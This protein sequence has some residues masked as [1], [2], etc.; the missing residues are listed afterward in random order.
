MTT[1][2]VLL[3]TILPAEE[4][5]LIS[6]CYSLELCIQMGILFLFSFCFLLLFISQLFARPPQTAILL[7]CTSF[8]W[9]WSCSL[10][11][12]QCY[13]PLYPKLYSLSYPNPI[14]LKTEE[15]QRK[16]GIETK[17]DTAGPS[18]AQKHLCVPRF[19]FAEKGCNPKGLP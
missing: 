8:S 13:E 4:G 11:P 19:L 15:N 9:G 2:S 17:Q 3:N 12:V 5:F 10:S 14:P 7:F 18:Q 6:P 1:E 16:V